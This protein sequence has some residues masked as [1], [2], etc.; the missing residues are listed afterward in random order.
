MNASCGVSAVVET[1]KL[2]NT[3]SAWIKMV[4]CPNY[5]GENKTP[6]EF[7]EIKQGNIITKL[8]ARN[9]FEPEGEG[10]TGGGVNKT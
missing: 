7:Y 4:R 1:W 5:T 2:P 9:G 6:V 8:V 3:R 10:N